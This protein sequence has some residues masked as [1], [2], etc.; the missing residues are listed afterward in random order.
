MANTT[1][2]IMIG[3]TA[4]RTVAGGGAW[5]GKGQVMAS[6]EGSIPAAAVRDQ[7]LNWEPV[8]VPNA[9]L[10]PCG[11]EEADYILPDGKPAKVSIRPGAVGIVRS[12]DGSP[13][14]QFK[15]GFNSASYG[16]MVNFTQEALQ[17][18]LPILNAGE[19][20]NGAQF[21]MTVALDKT[22]HD[23]KSGLD[24]LPYLMFHSSLDGSLANTWVPGSL[25]TI[26]DNQFAGQRTAARNA[27]RLVKF[28]RSRF[29]LT[30]EKVRDLRSALGVLQLEADAMSALV[31]ELVDV[32]L[33]RRDWIKVL[34][35]I[36]PQADNEAS[37]AA[38]TKSENRRNTVDA[39]YQNSPMVSQF[40][41]TAFGAVQA[42][43]TYAH[44]EQ[45]VRGSSRVERVFDR[46]I[47]GD[48]A[49]SDNATIAALETVLGREL[50]N[51]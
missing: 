43:N 10:I 39:L 41:G 32:E 13:L 2:K 21:F 24:F 4:Q 16:R 45:S 42:F 25:V 14:G 22:M 36:I 15:E 5:I 9:N 30:D 8:E 48:M 51:A 49:A 31:G 7:L 3:N 19:L 35:I 50:V 38:Q 12:D 40:T 37:K 26:C 1:S 47:R 11:V 18:S 46:V 28:K 44:H 23:S 27:G 17:G 29:S 6:Y 34:D 20:R 33:T